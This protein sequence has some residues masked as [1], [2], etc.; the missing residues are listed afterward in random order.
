MQRINPNLFEFINSSSLFITGG[1]GFFGRSLLRR[2]AEVHT[3]S[4]LRKNAVTVLTRNPEIFLNQYPEFSDVGWLH[5]V[6][7]NILDGLENVDALEGNYSHV[8]HAAADSTSGPQMP[9]LERY[10]QIVGGTRN[11]LDFA[12][13]ARAKKFLLTSS[14]GVYGSQP[15]A[16]EAFSETF[17]GMPDPM[18]ANNTYSVGKRVAEH[19]CA[20]YANKYGLNIVVARCFAFVGPDLPLNAHFAIGNFIRD[21]LNNAPIVI[22]GDGSPLRSYLYQS[23]LA[24]WLLALVERGLTGQSYNVGSDESLSILDLAHLVRKTLGKDIDIVT[25]GIVN[26]ESTIRNRYIPDIRKIRQEL[27]VSILTPLD[28]AVEKTAAWHVDCREKR[29]YA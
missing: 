6:R 26:S 28:K 14:G 24:D 12:V 11:V 5:L 10:D 19:L 15:P 3:L 29:N 1:T 9:L 18:H 27:S 17:L 16:V 2:I 21:A 4:P 25:K 22:N 7:G 23:D 13:K 20:L 8:I